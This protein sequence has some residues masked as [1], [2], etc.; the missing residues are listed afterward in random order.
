MAEA[1]RWLHLSDFHFGT[2]EYGEDSLAES[3]VNHI[4]GRPSGIPDLIFITG[5]IAFAG[6]YSQYEQFAQ[7]FFNPLIKLLG[8]DA[9]KRIFIVPGNHDL[10]RKTHKLI[11]RSALQDD[12]PRFFDPTEDGFGQRKEIIERFQGFTYADS[13]AIGGGWLESEA[14]VF[15]DRRTI[16][17][18]D[19]GILGINT[20]WHCQDKHDCEAITPG[21]NLVK[22]GLKQIKGCTLRIVLGHHPI[23]WFRDDER[24]SI[25]R[26][27]R[28]YG[29]V[30]LHGHLHRNE[31]KWHGRPGNYFLTVQAGAAFQAREDEKWKNRILYA[32]AVPDEGKL[33]VE[34]FAWS[35]KEGWVPEGGDDFP[36]DYYE[37]GRW[38]LPL[39]AAMETVP[40]PAGTVQPVA[41]P[42]AP[43][44]WQ[45]LTADFLAEQRQAPDRATVLAYYDGRIP[46]WPL[47]L[48]A[49]VPQRA[50]VAR[51]VQEFI[52]QQTA[53]KPAIRFLSGAG[54]EGKTTAAMQIAS[55]LVDHGWR[56]LW[57]RSDV[58]GLPH[59]FVELLPDTLG[60]WLIA[61]DDADLIARDLYDNARAGLPHVHF[62][63]A[64]RD[65]DWGTGEIEAW[66]WGRLHGYR[67]EVLN[68]LSEPDAKQIVDAWA[69]YGAEG[70]GD[71]AKTPLDQAAQRL[72]DAAQDHDARYKH[73][74]AFLGA[75]LRLR[76]GTEL[77]EHVARLLERLG[78]RPIAH[79]KGGE[80]K[81]LRDAL[82][83]IAAMHAEN[84]LFLS[85]PVLAKV[86][87]CKPGKLKADVLGPLGEEAA[88]DS[89]GRF[90]LT[91]HRAIA[92][93]AMELLQRRFQYDAEELYV[94][95]A[96][97]ARQVFLERDPAFGPV[98]EIGRWNFISDHFFD[99][100]Q[101]ELGIRL[102]MN[103]VAVEP[104]NPFLISKLAQLYR[105][106]DQS[107]AA[108]KV[109]REAQP[110]R[111]G[112]RPFYHEWA[113]CEGNAGNL[114]LSVWLDGLSLSD[115]AER[116]RL[117]TDTAPISLNGLSIACRVLFSR[118]PNE[119]LFIDGCGA[120]A[121]LGLE[122][123]PIPETRRHLE[124]NRGE[125]RQQGVT[126]IKPQEAL[127]VVK[128]VISLA[129]EHRE[130]DLPDWLPTH[131][132]LEFTQLAALLGLDRN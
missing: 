132:R 56:V 105:K 87:G 73:D 62:L 109:F 112:N 79:Q 19:L 39:P 106:D 113:A 46:S 29:V 33:W 111:E 91:R 38:A 61:T 130:A 48:S 104:T 117:G 65:T 124:N 21:A 27:F 18:I 126:G 26:L 95:M 50:V 81:T 63:L 9:E 100:G 77:R 32:E 71:L 107:E 89:V 127:S 122:L 69:R 45:W 72:A 93:A 44:G 3:I 116:R 103:L 25:E 75:M 70:L 84:L 42:P 110:V 94:E 10:D 51:L 114:A 52:D 66:R 30:Y 47:A 115:Q 118:Y 67:I 131:D 54:G 125:A 97:A 53:G 2:D 68:G 17:G 55:R 96:R 129:W 98:P 7:Q 20:A 119:R 16:Q 82:A 13:T 28:E 78:G 88:A 5:D 59:G 12:C 14:G 1:I 74:G 4:K 23:E 101:R 8:V 49:D 15:V 86:L 24:R 35:R 58:K 83:Y 64:A 6:Q 40:I 128:Q 11:K 76:K 22:E 36:I 90:I 80:P 85:K 60:P 108:A 34:P 92:E 102:A 99:Q 121:Q 123:R 43:D 120:A 57:R 37:A 31:S 41:P